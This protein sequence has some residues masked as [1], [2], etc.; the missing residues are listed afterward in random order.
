M[1]WTSSQCGQLHLS[2]DRQCAR[3]PCTSISTPVGARRFVFGQVK[4]RIA[5]AISLRRSE[6][7]LEDVPQPHDHLGAG[8]GPDCGEHS[9]SNFLN[10]RHAE[11]TLGSADRI[12]SALETLQAA[13][14]RR[15][16]PRSGTRCAAFTVAARIRQLVMMFRT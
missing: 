12:E 11:R 4:W 15:L 3:R 1:S 7:Y 13:Q 5:T 6:Q 14:T 8:N 16:H 9:E 10:D 2:V